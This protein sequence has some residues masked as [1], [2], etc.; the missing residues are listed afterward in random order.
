MHR[1]TSCK[2]VL[3]MALISLAITASGQLV[4]HA[5]AFLQ[6]GVESQHEALGR[7]LGAARYI[8][9][10]GRINP[11][12]LGWMESRYAIGGGYSSQF[13]GLGQMISASFAMAIDERSGFELSALRYGVDGLQNT[14]DWIDR[15]GTQDYRRITH[16]NVSDYALLASYG[17]QMPVEGLSA[18]GTLQLIYRHAGGFATGYGLGLNAGVRYEIGPWQMGATVHDA[19][20]TWTFW[21]LHRSRLSRR[22][23]DSVI[24]PTPGSDEELTI[25]SLA[26]YGSRA[27]PLGSKIEMGVAVA[28]RATFDGRSYAPLHLGQVA[29]N[30]ALGVWCSFANIVHVR[31]GARQFQ[32]I[33]EWKGRKTLILT[34]SGGLGVSFYGFTV[35][36]SFVAPLTGI[37]TRFTHLVSASYRFGAKPQPRHTS[38]GVDHIEM[39]PTVLPSLSP[40]R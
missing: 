9:A 3:T 22:V 2:W 18:G 5:N 6:I 4:R 36:Y 16:F 32:L 25:P 37:T 20:T 13:G 35:D 40:V 28:L 17:Q 8:P 34:P 10:L 11:A 14:L 15:W 23:K 21:S 38:E 19:T 12:S 30:P 31:M 1:K 39:D 24:N 29:I 33:E 27:I 7:T 26:L